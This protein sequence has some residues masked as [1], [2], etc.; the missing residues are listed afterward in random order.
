MTEDSRLCLCGKPVVPG[1]VYCQEFI[2]IL[3]E[4]DPWYEI[5]QREREEYERGWD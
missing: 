4:P 2:D 3:N 1:Q 5:E